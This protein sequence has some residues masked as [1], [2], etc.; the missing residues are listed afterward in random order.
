ME[1]RINM[2][3]NKLVIIVVASI[4]VCCG[5]AQ[6]EETGDFKRDQEMIDHLNANFDDFKTLVESDVRCDDRS[7][8]N[9]RNLN[10]DQPSYCREIKKK[11]GIFSIE[12]NEF[13]TYRYE[14]DWGRSY[15]RGYTFTNSPE[16]I[17]ETS[18]YNN[19]DSRPDK[20]L[21]LFEKRYRKID[22]EYQ[23]G[24][25]FILVDYFCD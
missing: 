14:W 15:D 25:W 16:N 7:L 20:D 11:L 21:C 12:G 1:E 5:C 8:E 13:I 17:S 22:T 2:I 24:S 6:P 18:I 23:D 19:L 4:L 9:L 10:E 3:T